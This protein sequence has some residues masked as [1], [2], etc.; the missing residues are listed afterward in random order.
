[1]AELK[2]YHCKRCG[3]DWLQKWPNIPEPKR[4]NRCK[5]LKWKS[6]RPI[7]KYMDKK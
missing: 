2:E 5:S 1:M 3:N 6:K 4:C 7:P